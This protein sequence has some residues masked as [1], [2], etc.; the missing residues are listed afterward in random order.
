[1][2]I[3]TIP[4]G[5]G[6]GDNIY[7]SAPSQ[8]GDQTVSVTSDANTGAARS[9]VVT[10]TATGVSP[11]TLT[12]NQAA[13]AVT[14]VFYNYLKF[15]GTAYIETTYV[16]PSGCSVRCS[17]GNETLKATQA[18][19]SATG[20]GGTIQLFYGGSTNSTRRQML[21]YYDSSSYL[22]SNRYLNFSYASY[23]YFMTSKRQGWGS[24]S[25]TFTKG[26]TH[27]TGGLRFGYGGTPYTGTMMTF[28]VYG[29]D[30]QN[31]TS[32]DAFDNYT[33]VA[34]FRPCTY[35]GVAGMW[36]VEGNTF[37]GNTAG[38]GTLT[39]TNSV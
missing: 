27:P 26:S 15:D 30:T 25:Y 11:V 35:N 9:K 3:T 12:V 16:L 5:D 6:S 4:W 7:L 29:S 38:S 37:F 32:Y 24:T 17:L 1:M 21:P 8:T 20:G 39:A 2:A 34:T 23:N 22:A 31:L 13:G 18:T 33:P 10:F 28:Y 14:P 36:Y 19:F